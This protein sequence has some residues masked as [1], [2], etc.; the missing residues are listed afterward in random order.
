MKATII[1]LIF[2]LFLIAPINSYSGLFWVSTPEECIDKY[3]G[4]TNCD[5]GVRALSVA[6]QKLYGKSK[7]SRE[8]EEA[9]KCILENTITMKSDL[10][11]RVSM[12]RCFD[13]K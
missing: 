3:I 7:I 4:K 6:C 5:K 2:S 1:F 13:K 10:A 12:K 11:V 9:Y 8:E